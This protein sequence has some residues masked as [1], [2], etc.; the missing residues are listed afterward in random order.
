[1]SC[2]SSS[3]CAILSNFR[4]CWEISSC[5]LVE[6]S[7]LLLKP[8]S[9]DSRRLRNL[10][11]VLTISRLTITPI[12]GFFLRVKNSPSV[13][14]THPHTQCHSSSYQNNK[15]MFLILKICIAWDQSTT[16]Q[17]SNIKSPLKLRWREN[18]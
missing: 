6:N 14:K 5:S 4:A 8:Y 7:S 10:K 12:T 2:K 1:M 13:K 16:D 3:S 18:M 17:L 11:S 15:Q 9:T